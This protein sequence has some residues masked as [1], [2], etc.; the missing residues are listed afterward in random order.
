MFAYPA[1]FGYRRRCLADGDL[2]TRTTTVVVSV[3]SF[4]IRAAVRKTTEKLRAEKPG[5][6]T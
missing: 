2:D 4:Y 5:G 3:A 6:G 1:V